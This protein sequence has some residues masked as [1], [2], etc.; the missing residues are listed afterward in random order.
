MFNFTS[1][2]KPATPT[3]AGFNL[4]PAG[5]TT[6][7]AGGGGTGFHLG[8]TTTSTTTTTT[9][10]AG[11]SGFAFGGTPTTTPA[12]PG[13]GSG[14]SF[15][16][17]GFGAA[18]TG[19]KTTPVTGAPGQGGF[20][21]SS[22]GVAGGGGAMVGGAATSQ[23]TEHVDDHIPYKDLAPRQFNE[24][25]ALIDYVRLSYP[26]SSAPAC[27]SIYV[28]LIRLPARSV[29]LYFFMVSCFVDFQIETGTEKA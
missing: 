5:T 4:T 9:P 21:F 8:S 6:P 20:S 10:A 22:T 13:S 3:A 27:V 7:A 16:G 11:G 18:S 24:L 29:C 15:G 23:L 14:F 2:Q 19:I 1:P 28:F 25:K 12:A 26:F 17:A